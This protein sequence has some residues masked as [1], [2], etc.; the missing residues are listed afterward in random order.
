MTHMDA[1]WHFQPKNNGAD[2]ARQLMKHRWT[3]ALGLGS[4]ST[5]DTTDCYLVSATDIEASRA[6]HDLQPLDILR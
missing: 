4:N 3:T 6:Q 2:R 1:P 5:F